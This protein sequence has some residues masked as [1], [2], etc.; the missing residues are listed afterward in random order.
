MAIKT[1]PLMEGANSYNKCRHISTLQHTHCHPQYYP[2]T[3]TTQPHIRT[4]LLRTPATSANLKYIRITG[5][6]T[7]VSNITT[8]RILHGLSEFRG[9]DPMG[10]G[11]VLSPV[12]LGNTTGNRHHQAISHVSTN[13]MFRSSLHMS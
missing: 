12:W 9:F 13:S 2:Y 6:L 1:T 8:Y 11:V 5:F 10:R 3:P 7:E 4:H